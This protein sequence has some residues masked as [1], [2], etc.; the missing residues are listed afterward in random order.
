LQ[1]EPGDLAEIIESGLRVRNW[2][3]ASS[4]ADEVIG[5]L[6]KGPKPAE[7]LNYHPSRKSADRARSLL[8]RN[9]EG[10]L[11]AAEQA[12]LDEMSLLDHLMTLVK[13]R[14]WQDSKAAS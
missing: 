3:G 8:E 12:E 6:A 10:K 1:V 5:F 11:T 13:S 14:A 2:A 9:R 7:I 4:L